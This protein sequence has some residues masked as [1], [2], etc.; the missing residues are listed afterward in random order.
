MLCIDV[1]PP[2]LPLCLGCCVHSWHVTSISLAL[3]GAL[4]FP[5]VMSPLGCGSTRPRRKRGGCLVS[6][7]ESVSTL[8]NTWTHL[9]NASFKQFYFAIKRQSAARSKFGKLYYTMILLMIRAWMLRQ[10]WKV[11]CI[12]GKITI[13]TWEQQNVDSNFIKTKKII[14]LH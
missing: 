8:S 10:R 11:C 5:P 3:E 13:E 2:H 7:P 6:F 9:N 14:H 12:L 1:I 4:P